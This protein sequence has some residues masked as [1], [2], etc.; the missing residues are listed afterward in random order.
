MW[1]IAPLFVLTSFTLM[2]HSFRT[3]MVVTME[4]RRLYT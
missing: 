1:R 3:F 4:N 2:S